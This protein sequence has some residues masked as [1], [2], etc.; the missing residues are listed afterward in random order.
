[1][2]LKLNVTHPE[3]A[4]L[5]EVIFD[6]QNQ[7]ASELLT[8]EDLGGE[9]LL[10]DTKFSLVWSVNTSERYSPRESNPFEV[11]GNVAVC[12]E[13]H[14]MDFGLPHYHATRQA[15]MVMANCDFTVRFDYEGQK[16][17]F[18]TGHNDDLFTVRHLNECI[19]RRLKAELGQKKT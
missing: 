1:M 10:G 6:L 19:A 7:L 13:S 16:W 5:V 14:T 8:T 2:K 15:Y 17:V 18:P 4:K 3:A 12:V 11:N 9:Y